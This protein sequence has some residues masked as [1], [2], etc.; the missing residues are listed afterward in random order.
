MFILLEISDNKVSVK[1]IDIF[2]V[3]MCILSTGF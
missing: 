1:A 2:S 3:S